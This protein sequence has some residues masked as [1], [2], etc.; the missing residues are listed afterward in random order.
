MRWIVTSVPTWLVGIVLIVG[1]PALAVA[2]KVLLSRKIPALKADSHNDVAGFLV[3]VVAVIYAVIVGFTIVSLYEAQ[4]GAENE[5]NTEAATLLQLHQ[6]DFVLGSG[7][8]AR[9]DSDIVQYADAV[10]MNWP[11]I[12]AGGESAKV[13][14]RLDDIYRTLRAYE[15]RTPFQR[16]FLDQAI[17]NTDSLS[18]ARVA[19]QLDAR[20]AQS[21]PVVLWIGILLTSTVTLGFALMFSL[22]DLRFA[23]TMVAGVAAV[24]AV[25][26][27]MLIE[28]SYPFLGSLSV[29]PE[30]FS[31]VA[32]LVSG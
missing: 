8:S 20:Q 6:G 13:Q 15:P 9:I 19:R 3:A 10:V 28:L 22:E 11:T 7:T 18:A 32:R 30:K 14:Q 16:D 5:V 17:E 2:T 25:N 1:I 27:F 29:G 31:D 4:V 23:C 26:L 12:A 21:L 24:L